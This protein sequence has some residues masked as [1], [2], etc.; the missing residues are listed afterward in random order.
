MTA[1][2]DVTKEELETSMLYA[3]EGLKRT[4]QYKEEQTEEVNYDD[5]LDLFKILREEFEKIGY[6]DQKYIEELK[7]LED[8]GERAKNPSNVSISELEK[9]IEQAEALRKDL[10]LDY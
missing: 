1:P 9:G 5:W 8:L 10:G 2:D 4:K 6:I 3:I 7:S